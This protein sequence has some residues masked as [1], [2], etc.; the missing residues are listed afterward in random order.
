MGL[1][2]DR[3][4]IHRFDPDARWTWAEER[5]VVRK[6]DVR[7]MVWACIMFCALEMDRANIK[8]A[9]TDNLLGDLGMTTNGMCPRSTGRE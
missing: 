3:E 5:R 4:N 2:C 8:Q 9:V 6:T 7:I 1:R